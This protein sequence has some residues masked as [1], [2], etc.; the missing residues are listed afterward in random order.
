MSRRLR[1]TADEYRML[2]CY[3]AV[4]GQALGDADQVEDILDEMR[5]VLDAKDDAAA[6]QIIEWWGGWDRGWQSHP[7]AESW[8]RAFRERWATP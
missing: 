1:L 7:T 4:N 5:R 8:S 2:R 3:E 6:G